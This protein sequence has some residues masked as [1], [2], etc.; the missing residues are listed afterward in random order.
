MVCSV[1]LFWLVVELELIG[2]KLAVMRLLTQSDVVETVSIY[3]M[4]RLVVQGV[5]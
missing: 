4:A 3:Q 2:L 5:D 1:V